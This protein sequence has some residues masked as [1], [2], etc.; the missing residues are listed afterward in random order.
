MSESIQFCVNSH[1]VDEVVGRLETLL[2]EKGIKLFCVVDHS[3]GYVASL[4][5]SI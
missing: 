2:Q 3:G 5:S 1:S 4:R